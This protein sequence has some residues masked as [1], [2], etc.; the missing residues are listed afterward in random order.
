[1][2][3]EHRSPEE[4]IEAV[5]E[6]VEATQEPFTSR[7][8]TRHI[9]TQRFQIAASTLLLM[10]RMGMTRRVDIQVEEKARR[11]VWVRDKANGAIA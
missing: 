6:F 10:E 1:M 11:I 2:T 9:R 8:V 3:S 4:D 5:F 7:D